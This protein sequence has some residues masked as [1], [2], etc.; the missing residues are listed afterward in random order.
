[1]RPLYALLVIAAAFAIAAPSALATN[2][3]QAG[4]YPAEITGAATESQSFGAESLSVKCAATSFTGALIE[5]LEEVEVS[6]TYAECTGGGTAATVS[7]EGC[8]YALK[9][10]STAVD[11]ACPSGKAVKIVGIVGNCEV[12]ISA[13]T[14][15]ATTEYSVS[16]SEPENLALKFNLSGIK[17]KKTKDGFL[18]P[19]SGT[20]EAT[21]GTLTGAVL[22]KGMKGGLEVG[23]QRK[24][25]APTKLCKQ[26][27]ATCP[28]NDEHKKDTLIEGASANVEFVLTGT[29]VISCGAAEVSGKTKEDVGNF[30]LQTTWAATFDS[31]TWAGKIG[32]GTQ[33]TVAVT[34]SAT[35]DILAIGGRNGDWRLGKTQLAIA[36]NLAG[37]KWCLYE[38]AGAKLELRG[39][40]EEK[41]TA[42][43]DRLFQFVAGEPGVFQCITQATWKGT[44]KIS[45]PQEFY[46][47]N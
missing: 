19:L 27:K 28:A 2:Y 18:C 41:A 24:P 31:C 21:N 37:F 6:P 45:S 30:R 25:A 32:N 4:G 1:M 38:A 7:M 29:E 33:C 12:Q 22:L 3:F 40:K 10:N 43:V 39:G 26:D 15:I 17:Y 8:T 5:P 9:A 46:V 44:Y 13:Q 23:M 36:C 47:T 11:L 42:V 14:G 20:G 35:V 16:G 34:P